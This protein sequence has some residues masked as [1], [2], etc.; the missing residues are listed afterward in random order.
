M[1][2]LKHTSHLAF[3]SWVPYIFNYWKIVWVSIVKIIEINWIN[4]LV[5]KI[6]WKNWTEWRAKK[7]G[8]EF[9]KGGD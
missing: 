5:M 1:P 2:F 7:F 6:N 3:G 8:K 4:V 9:K